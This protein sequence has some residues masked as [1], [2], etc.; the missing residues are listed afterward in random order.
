[1]IKKSLTFALC[2]VLSCLFLINSYASTQMM[3]GVDTAGIYGSETLKGLPIL[4]KKRGELINVS[5]F[6]GN[7][8]SVHGYNDVISG[9]CDKNDLIYSSTLYF[10]EI[11]IKLFNDKYSCLVDTAKY[12]YLFDVPG[13]EFK[14]PSD[15]DTPMLIQQE[16]FFNL[17][18]IAITLHSMGYKTVVTRAYQ[19][20]DENATTDYACGSRLDIE[21]YAGNYKIDIPLP[22]Y[23]ENG[24][25]VAYSRLEQIF[26]DKNFVRIETSDTFEDVNTPLYLPYEV[27]FNSLSYVI[28]D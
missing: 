15:A 24:E 3:I 5:L 1:M 11:G 27:D 16:T 22:E 21:I 23:D 20:L 8:M 28:M 17:R 25:V 6:A 7:V 12:M 2:L 13:L 10:A 19:Y 14:N 18:D 4:T 9:Y 26:I